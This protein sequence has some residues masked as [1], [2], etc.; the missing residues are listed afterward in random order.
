MLE[1]VLYILQIVVIVLSMTFSLIA[2]FKKKKKVTNSEEIEKIDKIINE[3][4]KN[5]I[6]QIQN[7]SKIQ[8]LEINNKTLQ[9]TIKNYI[10]KEL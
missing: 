3:Q 4:L 9:N 1:T 2:L 6:T 5:C 10:K 8:N 7:L